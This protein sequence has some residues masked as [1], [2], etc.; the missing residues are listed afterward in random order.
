[1]TE[2]KKIEVRLKESFEYAGCKMLSSI[3]MACPLCGV[4]VPAM[5]PHSCALT[6]KPKKPLKG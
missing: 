1:M 4:L 2:R 3:P 6:T 5:V